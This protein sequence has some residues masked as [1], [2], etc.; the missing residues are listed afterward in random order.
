MTVA[1]C[2]FRDIN[3]LKH[4]VIEE[5]ANEGKVTHSII[6]HMSPTSPRPIRWFNLRE[7]KE[8]F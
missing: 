2:F 6:H 3:G 5:A 1:V 8:Q 4:T 7:A